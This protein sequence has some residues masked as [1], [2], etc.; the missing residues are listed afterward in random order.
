MIAGDLIGIHDYEKRPERLLERLTQ[1]DDDLL[2]HERFYGHLV[3]L[4]GDT[5]RDRP[6]LLTEF[7]GIAFTPAEAQH[8]TWGYDRV[9]SSEDFLRRYEDLL[10]AVH[11]TGMAGF[12]YT[13]FADT[14]QEANG[15]VTAER[16]PKAP[17]AQLAAA[18]RGVERLEFQEIAPEATE[19][20]V[21]ADLSPDRSGLPRIE[22]G[23]V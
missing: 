1:S 3:L 18:T 12:C 21:D 13:Q 20:A 15:L 16:E 8:V 11:E 5:R 6:L 9:H 17:L 10:E 23:G 22:V 19:A 4:E 2:L 14:Y 7:G